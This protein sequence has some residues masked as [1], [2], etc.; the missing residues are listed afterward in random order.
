MALGRARARADVHE[1]KVSQAR[2]RQRAALASVRRLGKRTLTAQAKRAKQDQENKRAKTAASRVLPSIGGLRQ[3]PLCP[4][5]RTEH[6]DPGRNVRCNVDAFA[7]S[8]M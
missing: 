7:T 1:A 2:V 6:R 5:P 3:T 4:P 8:T